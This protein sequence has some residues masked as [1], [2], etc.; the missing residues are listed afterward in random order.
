MG[1]VIGFSRYVSSAGKAEQLAEH[2]GEDVVID[3]GTD[4]W[5]P[6]LEGT[7]TR[8]WDDGDE[9]WLAQIVVAGGL[10]TQTTEYVYLSDIACVEVK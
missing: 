5:S 8:I 3:W 10:A 7:L 2:V 6:P 1:T 4:A 9:G